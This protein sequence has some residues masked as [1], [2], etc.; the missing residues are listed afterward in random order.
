MK[1]INCHLSADDEHSYIYSNAFVLDIRRRYKYFFIGILFSDFYLTHPCE[2]SDDVVF[3]VQ[4]LLCKG[5]LDKD[6]SST[7]DTIVRVFFLT[8]MLVLLEKDEN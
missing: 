4:I 2:M 5:G 1:L 6:S 7:I 3:W 8:C